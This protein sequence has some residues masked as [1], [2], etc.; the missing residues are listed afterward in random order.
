MKK[1]KGGKIQ[2]SFS[3]MFS[4]SVQKEGKG[5]FFIVKHVY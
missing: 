1:R 5:E 2:F 4:H 3:L